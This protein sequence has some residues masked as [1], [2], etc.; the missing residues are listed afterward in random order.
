M[1]VYKDCVR[2]TWFAS[3]YYKDWTGR[4][5]KK[6]KRGFRTKKE[7]LEWQER[8]RTMTAGT[9]EMTFRDFSEVYL[10]DVRPKVRLNTMRKKEEIIEG[11]LLPNFGLMKMNEITPKAIMKWQT[12]MMEQ[13]DAQGQPK[14][15]KKTL[16]SYQGLLSSMMNHAVRYYSLKK[17]PVH[18]EYDPL[19][20]I[21]DA[22]PK[23]ILANTR[24]EMY[25]YEG[26]RICNLSD[27]LLNEE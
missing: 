24:H 26:I 23:L 3:F 12:M 25:D 21:R 4:N 7:A 18:R 6:M 16:E 10:N 11:V 1:P 27:W 22:Y 13:S 14:Y 9:L 5:R 17:N 20:K 8:F 15:A 2:G 19:L